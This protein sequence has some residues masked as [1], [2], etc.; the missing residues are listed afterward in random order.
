MRQMIDNEAPDIAMKIRS[1]QKLTNE[2][3]RKVRE[4]MDDAKKNLIR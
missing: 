4:L 1:G 2:E 3:A